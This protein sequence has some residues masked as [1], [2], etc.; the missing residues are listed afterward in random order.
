[1]SMKPMIGERFGRWVVVSGPIKESGRKMWGCRCDCGIEKNVNSYSLTSGRS[2]S[3]GCLKHEVG[4]ECGKAS[5]KHGHGYGTPTYH[6]WEAMIRR[7]N[8]GDDGTKIAYSYAHVKVC[9]RW[10][11]FENF[12]EDMGERPEGKSLDRIDFLGDYCPENCRW[13]TPSEQILNQRPRVNRWS[14]R[15]DKSVRIGAY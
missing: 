2:S 11:S 5:R 13:A 6:T 7:G 14:G 12:L 1:M 15:S 8:V 10:R 4:V 9:D 3:C